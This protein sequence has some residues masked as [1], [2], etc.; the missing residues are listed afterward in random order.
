MLTT[1]WEFAPLNPTWPHNTIHIWMARLQVEATTLQKLSLTLSADEHTRANRYRLPMIQQRF[2]ISRSVLRVILSRYLACSPC[3]ITFDYTPY[4][5]PKLCL[6]T[7]APTLHFNVAHS[8]NLAVY[9]I[10]GTTNV[11]IDIEY[12][13]NNVNIAQV[14]PYVLTPTEVQQL[15]TQPEPQHLTHFF[16][17]WT[18]KEA[19]VK[20][21]GKGLSLPIRTLDVSNNV[22]SLTA[23]NITQ[24][25][26]FTTFEPQVNYI[27]TLAAT[28]QM[29]QGPY[30]HYEHNKLT[31]S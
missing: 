27:A 30:F 28:Q 2:I 1:H 8:H 31:T 6:S 22:V 4:G 5:K 25:W 11:G 9:A 10:C 19:L 14:A 23:D 24:H 26:Q 21:I 7:N 17:Y 16:R 18:R 29:R 3:A 13:L 15:H 12:L 20:A